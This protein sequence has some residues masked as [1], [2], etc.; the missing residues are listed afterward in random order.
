MR[1]LK[2]NLLSQ[3]LLTLLNFDF[4][5]CEHIFLLIFVSKMNGVILFGLF[6]E[7]NNKKADA[8]KAKIIM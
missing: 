5:F 3:S 6:E 8:N 1:L 7:V 2:L 4:K